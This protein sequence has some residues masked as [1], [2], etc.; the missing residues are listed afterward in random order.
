MET[1]AQTVSQMIL[2]ANLPMEMVI[3][4]RPLPLRLT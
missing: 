3:I 2:K 1:P 4:S